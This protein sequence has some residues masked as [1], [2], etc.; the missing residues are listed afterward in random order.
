MIRIVT[1]LRFAFVLL[2]VMTAIL[3]FVFVRW[4][5]LTKIQWK[6]MDYLWLMLTTFGL[7]GLVERNRLIVANVD[8]YYNTWSIEGSARHIEYLFSRQ[9]V[10]FRHIRT[11]YS[12][13]NF[14]EIEDLFIQT[15]DWTTQ[16][17]EKVKPFL[18]KDMR[19]EGIEKLIIPEPMLQ[20]HVLE[21]VQS[22]ETYNQ[23]IDDR[24][25]LKVESKETELTSVAN[26]LAPI[27]LMLG[28]AIRF[29][30]TAGEIRLEKDAH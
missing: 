20:E 7:I 10:C 17:K 16:T 24:D 23:A 11:E 9:W 30:K 28:L 4:R 12:P 5:P 15:C 22:I 29:V 1:D 8:L 2:A 6:R 18:E 26:W 14:D 27:F 13:D 19:I 3:Y 25:R 21:I